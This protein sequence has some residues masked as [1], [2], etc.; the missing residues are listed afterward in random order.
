MTTNGPTKP[1]GARADLQQAVQ[2]LFSALE[3]EAR[4]RQP[5]AE[6]LL[7]ALATDEPPAQDGEQ[8]ERDASA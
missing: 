7:K 3:Q 1:G 5:K 6:A 2:N 8:P 4:A